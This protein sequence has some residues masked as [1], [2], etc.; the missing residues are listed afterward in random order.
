[1]PLCCLLPWQ[2]PSHNPEGTGSI[3]TTTT[4]T[5]VGSART[6]ETHPQSHDPNDRDLNSYFAATKLGAS[7]HSNWHRTSIQRL[8]V[9]VWSFKT[10]HLAMHVPPTIIRRSGTNPH[11]KTFLIAIIVSKRSMDK[12][13]RQHLV[14]VVARCHELVSFT[15]VKSAGSMERLFS[16]ELRK[17]RPIH[18]SIS[19]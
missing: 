15:A 16:S 18:V 12:D 13:L 4:T 14:S 19:F 17:R 9:E 5:A 1:M 6:A 11:P 7:Q 3:T 10:Y 8:R 2:A